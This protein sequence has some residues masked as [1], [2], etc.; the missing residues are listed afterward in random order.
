MYDYC[1]TSVDYECSK[2]HKTNDSEVLSENNLSDR[3]IDQVRRC[4]NCGH[5]K[6]ISSLSMTQGGKP[7]I[8][9]ANTQPKT[10]TF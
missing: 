4:K 1:Q 7:L 3:T 10:E 6:V 5:R 9:K 8:V 2:C